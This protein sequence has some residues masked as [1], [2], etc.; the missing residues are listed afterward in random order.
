MSSGSHTGEGLALV[1]VDCQCYGTMPDVTSRR[2]MAEWPRWVRGSAF[3]AAL[4]VLVLL[5]VAGGWRHRRTTSA[6]RRWTARS[7]SR[8]S[9]RRSRCCAT[10]TASRRCTPTTAATC[11]TRRGSSRR[12]T[13]SSRWTSA[14]T[15]PPAGSASCSASR[16]SRPT[17]TS[18]PWA[19]A[20]SRTASTTCSTPATR[21]YLDAYSDGVN[22]YLAGKSATQLSTEYTVLGL[23]GLDYKPEKW[24]PVDSLAWL[25]AM[26]WDLRGNMDEEI[27]RTRL[28]LG[29]SPE[30]VDELYPRYPYDR[31]API[32]PTP[33]GE[34]TARGTA[35]RARPGGAERPRGRT[36]RRRLDP[37]PDGPRRRHRLQQLGRLGRPHRLGQAAARQR[38]APQG[39]HARHLVPDGPALHARSTTT[40]RSTS[41][42]SPSPGCP[43]W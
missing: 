9:T 6:A 14:A 3:G 7:G 22:A 28:S 4:L 34:R 15:S 16:P 32:V 33:D 2:P 13:G 12:R 38:P 42:A 10:A 35:T 43:A 36:T 18:A 24:T 21:S 30:Q 17:C 25:K 20:G 5:L 40:A 39:D 27:A 11:S 37:R 31:H 1:V 29:R 26:A 23:G 41:A 8:A 19:G